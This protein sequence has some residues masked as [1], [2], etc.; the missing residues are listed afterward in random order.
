MITAHCTNCKDPIHDG[1]SITDGI[2]FSIE[3][4]S[5]QCYDVANPPAQGPLTKR[6]HDYWEAMANQPIEHCSYCGTEIE[7]S[8]H[9]CPYCDAS[10]LNRRSYAEDNVGSIPCE[11]CGV[12]FSTGFGLCDECKAC[13]AQCKDDS[14]LAKDMYEYARWLQYLA[15]ERYTKEA[16]PK[17]VRKQ[18]AFWV[19]CH[20]YANGYADLQKSW[21]E[22]MSALSGIAEYVVNE[23]VERTVDG[24]EYV[25]F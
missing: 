14:C 22:E 10:P 18:K 16:L 7:P 2:N 6:E 20:A 21:V 25:P 9:D 4:C 15:F 8:D 19:A 1:M 5:I 24:D 13:A 11:G 12:N 3:Y 23:T 17:L